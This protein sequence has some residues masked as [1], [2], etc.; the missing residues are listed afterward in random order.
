LAL[1]RGIWNDWG[2]STPGLDLAQKTKTS[3]SLALVVLAA[4]KGKRLKSALP[5]VLHPICGR[6]ALWHVVQAGL[7]A[8]PSKIVIVIGQGGPQVEAEV[9]SWRL[10]PAPVF[11]EQT[12]QLGTG[13]AVAVAEK[14]VGRVDDVLVANGDFDPVSPGA[15][16]GLL[17]SHRRARAAASVIV[18]ELDDPAG[19]GRVIR[20]G[21]RL[22]GVVEH[23]D[24]S[25]S[26]RAIREVA[27]NWI[28]FRRSDLFGALPLLDRENRQREYYLNRVLPILIEKGERVLAVNA[29]TGGALGL[30]SRGGLAAVERI[31]RSRI[32]AEH[33]EHGVT[34]IDPST[35]YVDVGVKIGPDTMIQPLTFL[36]GGTRL[37]RGCQIGPSTRIVDSSVGDGSVV[38]FSVVVGSEIG[39]GA[40]V[41]PFARLRPGTKIGDGAKAG[42]FVEVKNSTVG[43]DSKV[44]HL[45]YVG[46]ATI[47]RGVNLGAGT[48]T[49]NFDGYEKHATRID[50]GARIGS[51]TMLVAPVH[52]GKDA[53]T[54]AGSVITQDVPAGALAVE[55]SEQKNVR[56]YRRRKDAEHR[57]S[58]Q[59]KQTAK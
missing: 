2:P 21:D 47:G 34:M 12:E 23:V 41:G 54:G 35:T 52:V 1:G 19:Y 51:D 57:G 39:R 31:I 33:L 59:K 38:T 8:S 3:R 44:P 30:N 10:T 5:K 45:S 40:E 22:I 13:H 4:G 58:G 14:A 27:T 15:V 9:R 46:D 6:P 37:G 7:E 42:A 20:D 49:V 43:K 53:A 24:A 56:G 28:V 36:E 16:R 25:V 11:V 50:D 17:T 48:V 29:D 32:N 18:T 26:E 55:R